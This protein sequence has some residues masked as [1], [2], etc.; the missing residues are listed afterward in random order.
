MRLVSSL[1]TRTSLDLLRRQ[2]RVCGCPFRFLL[3]RRDPV[4]DR[5]IREIVAA[6]QFRDDL[7]CDFPRRRLREQVLRARLQIRHRDEF[8]P[9]TRSDRY[10]GQ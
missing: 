2:F 9:E 10:V 6:L 8:R 4:P 7:V 5:L 1:L 3:R